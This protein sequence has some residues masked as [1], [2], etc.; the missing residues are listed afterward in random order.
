MINRLIPVQIFALSLGLGLIL[1]WVLPGRFL[2]QAAWGSSLILVALMVAGWAIREFNTHRNPI[3]PRSLPKQ[4]VTSGPYAFTRNPMY[5]SLALV[6]L[7]LA[8]WLGSWPMLIAPLAFWLFMN[9]SYIPREEQ[10]VL[11]VLGEPYKEYLR[12]VRRWL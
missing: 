11:S 7:A 2:G 3:E 9:Y 8:L 5:L 4:L 6:L 10:K 12:K 1:H